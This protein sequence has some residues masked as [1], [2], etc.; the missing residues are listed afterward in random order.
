MKSTI[1]SKTF[2]PMAN[3]VDESWLENITQTSLS[4]AGVDELPQ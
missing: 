1:I 2:L 3:R 4:V